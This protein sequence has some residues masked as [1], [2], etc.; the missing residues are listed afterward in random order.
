MTVSGGDSRLQSNVIIGVFH[1]V[2]SLLINMVSK[3]AVRTYLGVEY[4]GLQTV[5][6][7]FCDIF[8][9]AFMG[10]GTAMMYS[11]YRPL[12][13]GKRKEQAEIYQYYRRIYRILTVAV[14]SIGSAAVFL[15]LVVVH[16]DIRVM[17]ITGTYFLYLGSVLIYN[18]LF[19]EYYY[20][21]ADQKRYI[22]CLVM[23]TVDGAALVFQV[24][25]LKTA[26]N[27]SLFLLCVLVK[28]IITYFILHSYIK[29]RYS[30]LLQEEGMPG[31][32]EQKEIRKNVKDLIIYRAGNVLV[33]S[34]D[35]IVI[36]DLLSTATAG[37]YSN[38][39]FVSMGIQS[40]ISSF[41]D[42]I[43]AKI[44]HSVSLDGRDKQYSDFLKLSA[45]NI[46]VNG[47][48][49]I[50]FY[51]L[52]QDFISL[53]MGAEVL[54][55]MKVPAI[56]ALNLYLTGIRQTTAAYRQ[57]AGLFQKVG[58]IV[59]GKGLLN[60]V[61]SYILGA[62]YGLMGILTATAVS[63]VITL[64]FYE[65]Y[66][67]YRYFGKSWKPEAVYQIVSGGLTYVILRI[68]GI[69]LQAMPAHSWFWLCIKGMLCLLLS[70]ACFFL[71]GAVVSKIIKKLGEK[72]L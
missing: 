61:L 31:T 59:L 56:V 36:S 12:A 53:W 42:S 15:V 72:Q 6:G 47:I 21:M 24:F 40:M 14:M 55:D 46:M 37:C 22:C 18:R 1:Q 10:I 48:T 57:S 60:L 7:N 71:F 58:Y 11:L 65:P 28:N 62:V 9:F 13:L 34:T 63:S 51:W 39:M 29:R 35:S 67:V 25:V 50:G 70:L 44:G 41:F 64:Y 32:A 17:E 23:S 45:V 27:Y 49:V 69:P 52:V 33:N 5:F 3:Y 66:M 2:L 8:T 19:L 20:I 43:L 38:Y 4:L 30:Y 26:Y 16:A 68:V 54:L